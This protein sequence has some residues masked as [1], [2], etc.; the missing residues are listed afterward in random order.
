MQALTDTTT[1]SRSEQQAGQTHPAA[2]NLASSWAR[3]RREVTP[4]AYPR[5]R[6][7]AAIRLTVGFFLVGVGALC[8]SHSHDGYAAIA[9]VGAAVTLS[10]GVMDGTA[11]RSARPRG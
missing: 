3:G 4:W 6:A 10:I 7:L 9:L 1:P 11:A 8:L 5:L 2:T